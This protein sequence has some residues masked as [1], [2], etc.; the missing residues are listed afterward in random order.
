MRTWSVTS[1]SCCLA[2]G[3]IGATMSS[4]ICLLAPVPP[5][6]SAGR[7]PRSF[8]E[9]CQSSVR[10]GPTKGSGCQW[11]AQPRAR[12]YWSV[13]RTY[14]LLNSARLFWDSFWTCVLYWDMADLQP[15][16]CRI[17]YEVVIKW[18]AQSVDYCLSVSAQLLL[19]LKDI[20]WNPMQVIE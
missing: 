15:E 14:S 17:D 20:I 5:K 19:R 16:K 10:P 8:Y 1:G 7:Y 12:R 11:P 18:L 13:N 4:Q 2:S 9:N 3:P 6:H